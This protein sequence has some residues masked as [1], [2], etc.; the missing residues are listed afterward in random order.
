VAAKGRWARSF[1]VV[2]GQRYPRAM[3]Y[4]VVIED[5][6]AAGWS[7]FTAIAPDE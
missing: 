3:G 2:L 6:P 7:Y 5:G 1:G 4:L